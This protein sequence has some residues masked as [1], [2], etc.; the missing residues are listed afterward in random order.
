ME[1]SILKPTQTTS[2]AGIHDKLR[3]RS[4]NYSPAADLTTAAYDNNFEEVIPQDDYSSAADLLLDSTNLNEGTN[5]I[6]DI[7]EETKRSNSMAS[8]SSWWQDAWNT[9]NN[10]R[11]NI[12][13]MSERGKLEKDIMPVL[14]DIDLQLDVLNTKKQ[15]KQLEANLPNLEQGSEEYNNA[16]QLK[17]ELTNKLTNLLPMYNESLNHY[18][19]VEGK[20]LDAREEAL[21]KAKERKIAEAKEV[22]DNINYYNQKLEEREANYKISKDFQA[23]EQANQNASI[24]DANYWKYVAPGLMGS[25]FATAEAY[26]GSLASAYLAQLGRQA[27]LRTATKFGGVQSAIVGEIAA[28]A[29]ALAG[30]AGTVISNVYS[31][32]RES[33]A[34]VHGAYRSKVE[35]ELKNRGIDPYSLVQDARKQL[36]S[37]NPNIN[38]SKLSDD[39]IIDMFVSGEIDLPNPEVNETRRN[40]RQGLDNVYTNNMALSALDIAE[41]AVALTPVSKMFGKILNPIT[42]TKAS[43]FLTK[44]IDD[45]V[46]GVIDY[47]RKLA[48]TKPI[49]RALTHTAGTLG[50]LGFLGAAE[51]LEEGQQDIFDYDYIKGKYDE[52]SANVLNSLIGYG[53]ASL[54]TAKIVLGMNG[55]EDLANDQMFWNDIKGGFALG[56]LMG[57]LPVGVSRAADLHSEFKAN[58]YV[59]D[60]IM[61][62]IA[63]KDDLLKA[64]IYTD[65]KATT[66]WN[67][68]DRSEKIINVLEGLKDNLPEGVTVEDI[69]AEIARAKNIMSTAQSY[70]TKNLAKQFDIPENSDEYNA[71]VVLQNASLEDM[72]KAQTNRANLHQINTEFF[73][74]SQST[75]E[76]AAYTVE[77]KAN[78]VQLAQMNIHINAL[79]NLKSAL[80]GSQE[81]AA[82]FGQDISSKYIN[83]SAHIVKEL[84]KKIKSITDARDNFAELNELGDPESIVMPSKEAEGSIIYQQQALAD[85]DVEDSKKRY[86]Q[87]RGIWTE[88]GDMYGKSFRKLDEDK[89]TKLK[90]SVKDRIAKFI[91]DTQENQEQLQQQQ[92]EAE[93]ISEEVSQEQITNIPEE[94]PV[95][96]PQVTPQPQKP[97]S[98]IMN[99]EAEI[100]D[101]IKIGW[102][103]APQKESKSEQSKPTQNARGIP[104]QEE[105]IPEQPAQTKSTKPSTAA[106]SSVSARGIVGSPEEMPIEKPKLQTKSE[107][108]V[109][110]AKSNR[111]IPGNIDEVPIVNTQKE[112]VTTAET[113]QKI[114]ETPKEEISFDEFNPNEYID[115][116]V[117]PELEA[118]LFAGEET[119]TPSVTLHKISDLGMPKDLSSYE[120]NAILT[121]NNQADKVDVASA[122]SELQDV[123]SD[124]LNNII[125]LDLFDGI[126]AN[127]GNSS[128][129]KVSHTLFYSYDSNQPIQKGYKSGKELST[130]LSNPKAFEESTFEFDVVSWNGDYKPGVESTYD[131][132]AV[133]VIIHHSTGDYVLSL[134]DPNG[135]RI[136]LNRIANTKKLSEDARTKLEAENDGAVKRLID[137]RNSIIKAFENK[138]PNEKLVPV[139]INRSNGK[140]NVNR[141]ADGKPIFRNIQEVKGF[142]IPS[143]PFEIT[144]DTVTFGI[145]TGVRGNNQV[146]DSEG[147]T[148]PGFGG[149]GTLYIYPKASQTPSGTNITNV[150]INVNRFSHE[151]AKAIYSLIVKHKASP[152]E[153][154][155]NSDGTE[156]GISAEKLLN[157]MVKFG[158]STMIRNDMKDK[159]PHLIP[160]QFHLDGDILYMGNFVYDT[161]KLTSQDKNDIINY[162]ENTM[163]WRINRD[164]AFGRIDEVFPEVKSYFNNH[165]DAETLSVF[166]DLIFNRNQFGTNNTPALSMLGWYTSQGLLKSDLQDTLFT[167]PFVFADGIKTVEQE[168]V[169]PIITE[170]PINQSPEVLKAP[171]SSRGKANPFFEG[172]EDFGAPKVYTEAPTTTIESEE[173]NW[174]RKKLGLS[175]DSIEVVDNVINM[176]KDGIQAMGLTKADSI[177]LW[178]GAEKGTAYHEAF[179][180]VS[181]LLL[182]PAE[183]HKLYEAYRKKNSFKGT[184]NQLEEALAEEFR[185][186][187]LTKSPSNDF[188]ITKFLKS[189]ANFINRWVNLT[190]TNLDN[191]YKRI[192]TG[193][194]SNKKINKK[195]KEEFIS[196][197]SDG[198]PFTIKGYKFKN[199][200]FAQFDEVVNA[201]V[202]RLFNIN[203]VT[204]ADDVSKLDFQKLYDD[205][206]PENVAQYEGLTDNQKSALN[207]VFDKFEDIFKP[208]VIKKINAYN[209]KAIDKSDNVDTQTEANVEG[210]GVGDA[211][212]QHILS[213]VEVSKKDNALGST[214]IFMATIPKATFVNGK[215]R[216]VA[217]PVTGLP[218]F[219][220]FNKSWNSILNNLHDCNTW[221]QLV[222]KVNT[223]AKHNA[224]FASL[225]WKL[226][227][228]N[229]EALQTQIVN[230]I[231]SAYHNMV[232][233]IADQSYVNGKLVNTIYINDSNFNR[234]TKVYPNLWNS[235]F[236]GDNNYMEI[237]DGKYIPNKANIQSIIKSYNSLAKVVQGAMLTPNKIIPRTNVK[238]IDYVS[239]DNLNVVKNKLLGLLGKAGINIDI[240]TLNDVIENHYYSENPIEA[241]NNLINSKGRG[242]MNSIFNFLLQNIS[243]INVTNPAE[244]NYGKFKLAGQD[245]NINNI[246][247]KLSIVTKL[248]SAYAIQNPNPEELTVLGTDGKLLYPISAHNYL[249]DM[250][251]YLN[252]DPSYAK[253]M[254]GVTYNVGKNGEGSMLLKHVLKGGKIKSNTMVGFKKQNSSDYGR[255][256]TQISPLEDY[257]MKMTFV[258]ND[259]I[260]LP[261]MGDSSMYNTISGMRLIHKHLQIDEDGKIKFDN[262]VTEQFI[263]Y[264]LAELDTVEQNYNNESKI[265]E[266]NAVK[267]YHTG[268]RNGYRFRY[269]DGFYN[270][271]DG[272]SKKVSFNEALELAEQLDKEQNA[273][274]TRPNVRAVLNQIRNDFNKFSF[275]D[276]SKLVNTYLKPQF[277]NE[278]KFAAELGV[279]EFDGKNLSSI[280]NVLLD[281]KRF[282]NAFAIYNK[283]SNPV[284]KNNTEAYA[285]MDVISDF[286]VNTMISVEE[287]EKVFIKDPAYYKD[288]VDK[289]KRLREILSTGTTPRIDYDPGN[290][291]NDLTHLNVGMLADNELP[292]M[293]LDNILNLARNS[294]ARTL[295]YSEGKT[296]AEVD[297]IINSNKLESE[298]SSIWDKAGDLAKANFGGY[299]EINQTDASV[300][301]SPEGYKQLVRRIDGW[302]N[303]VEEA[304]NLL[305]DPNAEWESDPEKYSKAL[306]VSMKPLK[307]MF[308]G[309]NYDVDLGLNIPIFDKMAMFPAHRIFSKGDMGKLLERMENRDNPIHMVAFESAVKVGQRS[310]IPFYL[311]KENKV[312]NQAGLDNM[313]SYKQDLKFFRRQLVTDPHHAAEQMFVS[314]AQKAM[315]GNLRDNLEYKTVL[316]N[317]VTGEQ[318]K[319]AVTGSLNALTNA[320]KKTIMNKFGITEENGEY[321]ID[322]NKLSDIL[323]EDATQSDMNQNVLEGLSIKDGKLVAPISGLSDNNWIESRIISLFNKE[324]IDTKTPGGMFIQM[325]SFTYNSIATASTNRKR[326]L[327]YINPDGSM[328]CVITINLLK[329]VIPGYDKMSFIEA[330]NWLLEHNVIGDNAKPIAIGYRIPAQGQSS[331]AVLKVVDIYPEQIGDTITLPDEFTKLT[332]SDFDIDKLYVA[333]FNINKDGDIVQF[334]DNI[335]EMWTAREEEIRNTGIDDDEYIAKEKYKFMNENTVYDL[336]SKEA[337]QNRLI[338]MY[339]AVIGNIDNFAETRLPL[340]TTT[341][342]LKDNILKEVDE[343]SGVGKRKID[344]PLYYLTPQFQSRTK[345]ELNGGKAGIGPFALNSAHHVLGQLVKLEYKP[346]QTLTKY[347]LGN[348]F[349]I[350]GKD[351]KRILDWL[352]AM[353]NAHVDVAK[354]PY[355]MRLNVVQWTYNMTNFLLRSGVGENTFYFLPQQIL[356]DIANEIAKSSGKYGVPDGLSR[357]AVENKAVKKILNK[358]ISKAR[359]LLKNSKGDKQISKIYIDYISNFIAGNAKIKKSSKDSVIL[360]NSKS[361]DKSYLKDQLK[362]EETFEWYFNQLLIYSTFYELSPYAKDMSNLVNLSQ[363]DTKK[364]GNNFGLQ[365]SFLYRW[366]NFLLNPDNKFMNARDMFY[367]TFLI[368]K[369]RQGVIFPKNAFSNKWLRTSPA[370]EEMRMKLFALTDGLGSKDT[371]YINGITRSIESSYKAAFF[372]KFVEENDINVYELMFGEDSVAK[373]LT[374]FKQSI[375][376]G[377]YPDLLASDGSITNAIISQLNEKPK[378]SSMDLDLPNFIQYNSI[379]DSNGNIDNAMIRSWEELLDSDHPEV[380]KLAED[381]VL[382]AFYTS[383]DTSGAN[384]IFKYVPNEYRE[385]IGYFDYIRDLESNSDKLKAVVSLDEVFKNNWNNDDIVPTVELT[386][387]AVDEQGIYT[388]TVPG[389][390]TPINGNN[391]VVLD[392]E[393]YNYPLIFTNTFASSIDSIG[394]NADGQPLYSPFVKVKLKGSNPAGIMLYKQV[395]LIK[396]KPV[397]MLVNKKGISYKGSNLVEYGRSSMIDTNNPL[398]NGELSIEKIYNA[399]SKSPAFAEWSDYIAQLNPENDGLSYIT[400]YLPINAALQTSPTDISMVDGEVKQISDDLGSA[401]DE[402]VFNDVFDGLKQVKIKIPGTDVS[403]ERAKY[404][405]SELKKAELNSEEISGVI[406]YGINLIDWNESK[407]VVDLFNDETF[408]SDVDQILTSYV[409]KNPDIEGTDFSELDKNVKLSNILERIVEDSGAFVKED[410]SQLNIWNDTN[411]FPDTEMNHCIK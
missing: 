86:N 242:E 134:K 272:K 337:N 368:N 132:A 123:D 390:F 84:N 153:I 329:H 1:N 109:K 325:S 312:I 271:I 347:N 235:A 313:I 183:R 117:S 177:I 26:G 160:K 290:E 277:I 217:S 267:N 354:D 129:D 189:V 340:D 35:E 273:T 199:I 70:T 168:I 324:I 228:V 393:R 99:P 118:D 321:S 91:A 284:V 244:E 71:F 137:Y 179:H 159:V 253:K 224:F 360:P 18:G 214:K 245:A 363:I 14:D 374:R 40:A 210:E 46:D 348:M 23:K 165:P 269:F 85:I 22:Q 48:Y 192:E 395:A 120:Q 185:E 90:S 135:A 319:N 236:L 47:N 28:N 136:L 141:D 212:A 357:N 243:E 254:S 406:N 297:E 339:M 211:L 148:L 157:F 280:K 365:E 358:Y 317:K 34:Q 279:I 338:E 130:L 104:M 409:E 204:L 361:L 203:D 276:K 25:S 220:D 373:R 83:N 399:T 259:H 119:Y 252:T 176:V 149:S 10:S 92:A 63:S 382:Y 31:R 97:V 53:D 94:Q 77:Q 356:K 222:A 140:F 114:E 336:N 197:Y 89:Q 182:S 237:K 69:D 100:E 188:R 233:V 379:K 330:K 381:L 163:H 198:A 384:S 152:I 378:V 74:D 147:K 320:G 240:D 15:L 121:G 377:K 78:A 398:K 145:G 171:S 263:N 166:K 349:D 42:K 265:N 266:K 164:N 394:V 115:E 328:D 3:D 291:L 180:R 226:T 258:A 389:V 230:T 250:V 54:R 238:Y 362:K 68:P 32:E 202:A 341:D 400:D 246:Y 106:P 51:G 216:P 262:A 79:E 292:S 275:N 299:D 397:Y 155:K 150:Q 116:D 144:K 296:Q 17:T 314:Q 205:L 316:G 213:P 8:T 107:V 225:A 278:L 372:N 255:K 264:F 281:T 207:E 196:R 294:I 88:Q 219:D 103:E 268:K 124:T 286:F 283:N 310:K 142:D 287:V 256:Y 41:T 295:L 249:S 298:Y 146:V 227:K 98:T 7:T 56:L 57:G 241:F 387:E 139:I 403:V 231:R 274:D 218:M 110:T 108:K 306:G 128:V 331:T 383:G 73:A 391:T 234:A 80:E 345:D 60:I 156:T 352:S 172:M 186:R 45:I 327:N 408:A 301:L 303:D 20:D 315:M 39:T 223:F 402:E 309:D 404:L 175:S 322:I 19:E 174:I 318:L 288:T 87:L 5:P 260:V 131:S 375:K 385:K 371:D 364:F 76:M 251:Q 411:E 52:R 344:S 125:D 194:F 167:A 285:A 215:V 232:D 11:D 102:E 33:L 62:N 305:N 184:D 190:G 304:F 111:G 58:K 55:D 200:T 161:T 127:A 261:T 376:D 24:F 96:N 43:K 4:R 229:N 392:G 335:E 49:K 396:G 122:L 75:P 282:D 105:L 300:I 27:A 93:P 353:I 13:L 44:K 308:F 343:L 158:K 332:G 201:L 162:I 367:N 270:V 36:S 401:Y 38:T 113:R 170:K 29:A 370:F 2:T 355:I 178:K 208:E 248:A 95:V 82:K 307:M 302:T 181:L 126:I 323:I 209:I 173:I 59:R 366:K 21:I 6:E 333:R 239:G 386:Q 257:I 369:L 101:D 311:D 64:S 247:S 66:S 30:I 169:K 206:H 342:Y 72:Q 388:K 191:I 326:R 65:K 61:D 407:A 410:P 16:I 151:A 351:G 359:K 154:I 195:S 138:K 193:Y 112:P 12:N 81:A 67:R 380:R 9:F 221:D 143:N 289:I 405:I 350:L 50:K 37:N 334:N 133:R 187:Q 346:T 293:E